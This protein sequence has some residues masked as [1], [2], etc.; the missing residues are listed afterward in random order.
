MS[1]KWY[2]SHAETISQNTIG[3]LV[4]FI[5]LHIWGLSVTESF[6]LQAI[7]FVTSYIRSY[8]IRRLFNRLGH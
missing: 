4:G 2:I 6:G 8:V 5:I 7:F 3:L 1:Q